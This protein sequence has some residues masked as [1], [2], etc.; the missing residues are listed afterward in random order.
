MGN[1]SLCNEDLATFRYLKNK[2]DP[3]LVLTLFMNYVVAAEHAYSA[4]TVFIN[5]LLI[6]HSQSDIRFFATLFIG[7]DELW[8]FWVTAACGKTAAAKFRAEIRLSSSNTPECSN[9]YY[10]FVQRHWR[11]L[12]NA[13]SEI[14]SSQ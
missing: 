12:P 1:I 2:L 6:T 9:I 11:R 8:H 10:R 13:T 14:V 4:N 5:H 3:Y 7:K